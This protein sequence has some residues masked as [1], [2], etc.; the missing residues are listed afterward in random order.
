MKPRLHVLL[1]IALLVGCGQ[2]PGSTDNSDA[3]TTGGK[4]DEHQ[5]PFLAIWRKHDGLREGSEAPYLRIA[6]WNDGRMLFAKDA[7]KWGHDLR[8][9]R[10]TAD[11]VAQLKKALL[12]TGVF[13]LKGY[14]YLVP[15]APCDCVMLDLLDKKQMLYWD[16]VE[17]PGYGIN[18][19]PKPHHLKFKECWKAVNKLALEARPEKSDKVKERFSRP[20]ESWHLKKAIQ[21]E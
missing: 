17:T 1:A 15:D 7:G 11:R 3:K 9:G 18:I 10:I 5:R 2:L 13:D 16:E 21:S 8:Q 19:S 6:I 12:A 14:C 4:G 20:P